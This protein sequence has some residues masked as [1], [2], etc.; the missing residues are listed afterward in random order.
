MSRIK[1][2]AYPGLAQDALL[3]HPYGNSGHQRGTNQHLLTYISMVARWIG[4]ERMSTSQQ[5]T[6]SNNSHH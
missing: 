1:M 4:K 2:T 3:L 6:N 5:I